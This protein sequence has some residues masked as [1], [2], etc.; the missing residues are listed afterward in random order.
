MHPVR[1]YQICTRCIMDTSDPLIEFNSA[2]ICNHCRGYEHQKQTMVWDEETRETRLQALVGAIRNSG[3]KH[4]FDCLIGVSGGVD[5]T[6]VAY[7]VKKLG[8]RPLAVH[9][10][11]GWNSE[12]AVSNIKKTLDTL[13]IPLDTEVLDWEEF[14]DLQLA[15]LKASTPDSEIP[16][17]HAITAVLMQRARQ[18]GIKYVIMGSNVSSEAIMPSSWSNGIRDW[19]YI[20]SVHA[21]FGT[22]PL[23]S[24]P[25]FTLLQFIFSRTVYGLRWVNILDSID[26]DKARAM[27]VIEDELGWVYYGGKHYESIYTRFFQSYILPRKFG[28]DKRRAH[29]STLVMSGTITREGALKA[30]EEPICEEGLLRQDKQYVIKKLGLTEAEFEE[31]MARA[32]RTIADYPAYE[33]TLLLRVLRACYRLPRTLKAALSKASPGG[34][35]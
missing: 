14:K 28:Y 29:L 6:Y 19:K 23:R 18:H 16:T 21:R 12:L 20:K 32:P 13:E 10:D 35:A 5:S 27:K 31:L 9:M 15:F 8:L 3:K 11:N 17:D 2:G 25:R 1:P 22:V 30:M 4:E 33:N 7:Q 26:Y 24:F 34:A